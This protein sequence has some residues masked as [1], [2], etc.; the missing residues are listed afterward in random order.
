MRNEFEIDLSCSRFV[1]WAVDN[2]FNCEGSSTHEVSDKELGLVKKKLGNLGVDISQYVNDSGCPRR[3]ANEDDAIRSLF[4]YGARDCIL[5]L[6]REAMNKSRDLRGLCVN[7]SQI[8][9][10]ASAT[11]TDGGNVML[12]YRFVFSLRGFWEN[13]EEGERLTDPD[14]EITQGALKEFEPFGLFRGSI[15]LDF[16][17]NEVSYEA[18]C[19]VNPSEQDPQNREDT[20]DV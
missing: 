3:G 17:K 19:R 9:V 1:D 12:K 4:S 8:L 15:T 10:K 11:E 13:V 20:A 14:C 16:T 7:R 5:Y 18:P 2:Y 6:L